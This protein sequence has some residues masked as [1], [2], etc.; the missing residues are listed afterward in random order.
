M[1]H[2]MGASQQPFRREDRNKWMKYTTSQPTLDETV[3]KRFAGTVASAA[4]D[5]EFFQSNILIS[6]VGAMSSLGVPFSTRPAQAVRDSS[7][8]FGGCVITATSLS[9]TKTLVRRM[10]PPRLGSGF[11]LSFVV[12]VV[13]S[14]QLRWKRLQRRG[15]TTRQAVQESEEQ[16]DGVS[17]AL[18][19]A[20]MKFR[21]EVSKP[22]AEIDLTWAAALLAMHA[23]PEMDPEKVVL[24]P[25]AQLSREFRERLDECEG[26][27]E[28]DGG[29]AGLP[30]QIQLQMR[31]AG[32]C[33]F[34]AEQGFKGCPRTEEG[35]YNAEN[36]R[37]ERVLQ[38]RCG[39]PITLSLVYMN[40]GRS[41]GLQL[42]GMNFPGHFLL[43]FG[44]GHSAGLLDAFENRTYTESEAETYLSQLYGQQIKL[45]SSWM[46]MPRLPNKMFLLRMI[47]NLKGVYERGENVAQAARIVQYANCLYDD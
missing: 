33:A 19:E 42:Q 30:E 46:E 44:K 4:K 36:S 32:L 3:A 20:L 1:L 21:A 38:R 16:L 27:V 8:G 26:D 35:Y 13:R 22:D 14:G 15:S 7:S 39:I 37:I 28:E 6:C 34:M 9:R 11:S 5:L 10:P 29:A 45:S 25:L 47:S 41:C 43:G 17:K 40:V 31:A 23:N 18:R 12:L 2:C 24:Q